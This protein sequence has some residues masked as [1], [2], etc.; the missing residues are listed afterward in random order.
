LRDNNSEKCRK[1]FVQ[2]NLMYGCSLHNL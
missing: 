2:R 1:I